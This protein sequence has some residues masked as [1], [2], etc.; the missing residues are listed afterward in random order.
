[1]KTQQR[2]AG[3]ASYSMKTSRL[4]CLLQGGHFH[5]TPP[6]RLWLRGQGIVDVTHG[7]ASRCALSVA[8]T[9]H[10]LIAGK[11][12]PLSF[13]HKPM[14]D[15]EKQRIE[16][17]GG[18]VSNTGG[19]PRVNGN[20]NLSRAIGDLKYKANKNLPPEA[21]IITAHPDVRVF[22]LTTADEYFLLACDGIWDVITNE[23]CFTTV[24][25]LLHK[26]Q[27]RPNL[28]QKLAKQLPLDLLTKTSVFCVYSLR[29]AD[30]DNVEQSRRDRAQAHRHDAGACTSHGAP[31]CVESCKA[32]QVHACA[33]TGRLQRQCVTPA[34]VH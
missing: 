33:Q 34:I 12:V 27:Q 11:A 28:F 30:V 32:V 31:S 7:T 20:L 15:D 5:T 18:T 29:V 19:I 2:G 8:F 16:H 6:L 4:A 26:S 3:Y 10:F 14:H 24:S 17:A 25:Q 21:Q 13:D 23:V 9:D 22:E 1:M